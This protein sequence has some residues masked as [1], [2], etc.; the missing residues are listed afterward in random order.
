[1]IDFIGVDPDAGGDGWS[2]L[3]W[4]DISIPA[5]SSAHLQPLLDEF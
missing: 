5:V 3:D 1:V 2:G 4:L